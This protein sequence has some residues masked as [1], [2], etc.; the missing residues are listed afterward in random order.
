MRGTAFHDRFVLAV[1]ALFFCLH[2]AWLPGHLEDIDSINF[3]LGMRHYDV[4][5]HQPHPPGYPLF[6]AIARMLAVAVSPLAPDPATRDAIAMAVLAG[7]SGAAVVLLLYRILRALRDDPH[8]GAAATT[9]AVLAVVLVAATPLFWVTAS[10]PLSDMP[11]LAGA[12][13]CQWLLLRAARPDA[14]WRSAATAALLCGIATGLR[15]QVTWLVVPLLAWVLLRVWRRDDLRAAR[16]CASWRSAATAALL[17]GI[18]T[19]LR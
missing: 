7:L 8:A 14:S 5:A 16:P 4:A 9:P 6:I 11:G 1:A 13:A 2:L 17:C 3:A 18:A 12:L 10:R 15:S 19:G